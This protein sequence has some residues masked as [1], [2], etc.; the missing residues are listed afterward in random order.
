V[1]LIGN[2]FHLP[3]ATLYLSLLGELM[4]ISC[5]AF[6][7]LRRS[8]FANY[9]ALL[10]LPFLLVL[11]CAFLQLIWP[12]FLPLGLLFLIPAVLLA[13]QIEKAG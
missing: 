6:F 1:Q 5:L 7:W 11:A 13:V 3:S 9:R 10:N 8:F 4:L 12:I 2:I